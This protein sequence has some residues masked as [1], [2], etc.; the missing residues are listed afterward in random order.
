ML[1]ALI[2]VSAC[3][4]TTQVP[5]VAPATPGPIRSENLVHAEVRRVEIRAS[6]SAEAII[7]LSIDDGYHVNANPATFPYLIPTELVVPP[8]DG[9]TAGSVSYPAA[10]KKKFE[11]AGDE[12]AV[13]EGQVELKTT[14]QAAASAPKGERSISATLRVQACNN[15]VCYPPGSINLQIPLSIR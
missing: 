14:L 8:A 12:L 7:R 9:L 11:F 3:T 4:R 2:F 6:G 10:L 5:V 13:Y 15:Q 1:L